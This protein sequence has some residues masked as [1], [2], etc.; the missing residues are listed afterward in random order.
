MAKF[1]RMSHSHDPAGCLSILTLSLLAYM[2]TPLVRPFLVYSI[3][4]FTVRKQVEQG[5][6][7]WVVTWVYHAL[8]KMAWTKIDCHPPPFGWIT[9]DC[10]GTAFKVLHRRWRHEAK[11]GVILSHNGQIFNNFREKYCD[12]YWLSMQTSSY[13]SCDINWIVI[14][15]DR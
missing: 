1:G 3:P 12:R 11:Y 7:H 10:L 13:Q 15:T 4:W 8:S 14:C 6:R 5:C 2:V 9:N